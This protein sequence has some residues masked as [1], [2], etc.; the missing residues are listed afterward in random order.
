[1]DLSAQMILF[2]KV[3]ESQSFSAAA[4]SLGQTTSAV[5]RQIG[6]LEDRFKVRLVNRTS[7]G[8]T[9][10]DEG[11]TFYEHCHN[12]AVSVADAEDL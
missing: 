3:V 2:A 11:K 4:R 1:M 10:T 5:S 7:T 12:L 6:A 9:L 8:L